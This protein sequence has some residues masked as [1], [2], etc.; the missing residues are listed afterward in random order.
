MENIHLA[1][2]APFNPESEQIL[3]E[4]TLDNYEI[5]KAG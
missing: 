1:K 3:T 4:K 5:I 2:S